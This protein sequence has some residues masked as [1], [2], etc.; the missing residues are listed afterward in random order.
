MSTAAGGDPDDPALARLEQALASNSK[1]AAAHRAMARAREERGDELARLAHLIAAQTLEAHAAESPSASTTEL[2]K[3]AT[4]YFMKGDHAAAESWYRLV[5][6]LDPNVAS[7]HQNLAAIHAERG[8]LAQAE[9]SR[10]RA[11][12]IQRIFV[13]PVEAP[14]RQLLILCAGRT[15]GNVP[16]ETLLSSGRSGR[17][18]YVI[19]F[20]GEEEDGQL[21][22]FDLVFNA[23][24]EPD[25]AASLARRLDRFA[26]R[27]GRPV[28]NDSAAVGAT[29]RHRLAD[30]LG[31][32]GDVLL[33]PCRR[34]DKP[35][36]LRAD[37]LDRLRQ[38]GLTLP[39]LA[40][41]A[42][43]HGGHGLVRCTTLE[44]LEQTLQE[45]DGP[46]YLTGFRD[47]RSGD[48]HY[49][50]YRIV[51]VNRTPYAYHLAISAHWMVHYHSADM[52][53]HPW[54]LDE[55][56]RFL[57]DPAG[58]LGDKAMAAIA[59]IGRRLDLDYAGVDFAILPDG[60]VFVFEA[61]ATM[62]VH[63]ER[64]NGPLA[65][66]NPHVQRIV[67]AF[68]QLLADRAGL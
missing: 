50:K 29:Q 65:Y 41:P 15:A 2:C 9:Q 56:R 53:A 54:K 12:A 27:C 58:A 46:H 30:R 62:L 6:Q 68:E 36:P 11:Y 1:D 34:D 48:G 19:D 55:E 17:I 37:L 7:A 51:F 31:D 5:L 47:L 21:P 18:K 59:A 25:V 20:A 28:L 26:A 16:F 43:T 40:R 14:A 52:A 66:R 32:L 33:A 24:G 3:V 8:E 64:G 49:R 10:Q 13:E 39:V 38:A 60:R 22:A 63:F 45:I 57:E 61:N 23:I 44:G 67:D 42:G 4:G 35:A